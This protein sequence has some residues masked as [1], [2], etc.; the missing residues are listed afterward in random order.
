MYLIG[1]EM[2]GGPKQLGE[3]ISENMNVV[4]QLRQQRAQATTTLIGLLYG[5]S[6]ASTFAFFIG[7]QVVNIL[8][9]MTLDL[10][11]SGQFDVNSLIN[12]QVYNIPLIEFLLIIVIV[13]N[14]LLSSLMIRTTDGGHK[15]NAYMHFV[16]LLWLGSLISVFTKSMVSSFLAI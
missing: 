16:I 2:G 6:A 11:T 3:L 12:T 8:A 10:T 14:A 15:L 1:R 5:I 7:L 9:S 13:F 4:L